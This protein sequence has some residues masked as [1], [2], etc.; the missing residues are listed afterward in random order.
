MIAKDALFSAVGF[1][2]VCSLKWKVR[3]WLCNIMNELFTLV[4][5]FEHVFFVFS[6][7]ASDNYCGSIWVCPNVPMRKFVCF[8]VNLKCCTMRSIDMC[9]CLENFHF[10][11][12][13]VS[14]AGFYWLMGKLYGLMV[15]LKGVTSIDVC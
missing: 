7:M 9:R 2:L 10:M 8:N 5:L 15:C 13:N 12:L 14:I 6:F 3:T 11:S 1:F 4:V